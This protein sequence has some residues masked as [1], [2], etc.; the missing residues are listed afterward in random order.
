VNLSE[1]LWLARG[2]GEI[3]R[4]ERIQALIFPFFFDEV[5][6]YEAVAGETTDVSEEPVSEG[7]RG[8]EIMALV[9]D[10]FIPRLRVAGTLVQVVAPAQE[11]N[12]EG[13]PE[14]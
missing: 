1:Y 8:W 12:G 13:P 6:V 9:L 11:V 14:P 4:I 3:K 2:E 10:R 7:A 5:H